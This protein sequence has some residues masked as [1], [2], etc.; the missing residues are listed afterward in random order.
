[1]YAFTFSGAVE[2]VRQ[3][4]ECGGAPESVLLALSS[5]LFGAAKPGHAVALLEHAAAAGGATPALT[6]STLG[7][8]LKLK[9]VRMIFVYAR[10]E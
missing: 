9:Q 5:E 1:M 3:L 8:L 7:C 10:L 4:G 2:T 6:L